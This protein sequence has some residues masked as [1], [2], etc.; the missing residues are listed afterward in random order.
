MGVGGS[1]NPS[2]TVI[3]PA[4]NAFNQRLKIEMSYGLTPAFWAGNNQYY[5]NESFSGLN[6]IFLPFIIN[7]GVVIP[8]KYGNFSIYVNYMNMSNLGF[9]HGNNNDLGVGKI[10]S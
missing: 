4:S 8:S 1:D 5:T 7:A 3:N 9:G 6:D 10:G 2:G